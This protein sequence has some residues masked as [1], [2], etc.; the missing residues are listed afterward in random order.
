MS[1]KILYIGRALSGGRIYLTLKDLITH[2]HILGLSR[3]GKS[4]WLYHVILELLRLGKQFL[5]LDPHGSLY[6]DVV[7]YLAARWYT[8]RIVLFDPSYEKRIV[9]FN[10]FLTSYTD[11]ARI[12]TKAERMCQATLKVFGLKN[13]DQFGNIERWLR[14]IYY[15]ILECRLTICELRYFIYWQYE[16]ERNQIIDDLSSDAVREDL[17]EFY[18]TGKAEFNKNISSTRNK[19]QRFTHPHMRR[20]MGL[21][22]NNVE[23]D[24]IVKGNYNLLCNLQAAEDDLAGR[25]NMKV[26]GTLMIS[27][28]WEITRKRT[29]P[30][31]LYLI[32]DEMQ[33]FLTPDLAQML[34]QSAKYG[35]HCIL[36]HQHPG[37]LTAEIEVA[38]K[39]AQTKI[40][41]STEEKPK[42]QK[43]FSLRLADH[44]TVE[45][46]APEIRM[47]NVR[48][49]RVEQYVAYLTQFFMT[50]DQVD[51]RL[52]KLT[53]GSAVSPDRELTEEDFIR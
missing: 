2:L 22:E 52:P 20:I 47:L 26:L 15:V 40:F 48:P 6:R 32:V 10:P 43:Q 38:I 12:M 25:E 33:E 50:A 31:E 9:G 7:S 13:S 30:R 11:E 49:Q 44:T 18:A 27:E 1:N 36:A 23:L 24:S 34:P 16:Q 51:R 4:V 8:R 42:K 41:F 45:A 35:L 37:Q 5:L 53:S 3:S 28:L 17:R 14:S 29:R 19:L 21:R 46:Q 39:N